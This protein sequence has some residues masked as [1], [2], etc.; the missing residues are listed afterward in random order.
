MI[1]CVLQTNTIQIKHKKVRIPTGRRLT[2]WLFTRCGGVEFGATEDKSILSSRAKFI[3]P[4]CILHCFWSHD[5]KLFNLKKS[6]KL[7]NVKI[8][9]GSCAQ[10]TKMCTFYF[11][12]NV[13]QLW[14]KIQK[15]ITW[16]IPCGTKTTCTKTS[17]LLCSH[18]HL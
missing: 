2:S 10:S 13:K 3:A 5:L 9:C 11:V 18:L 17:D 1:K 8:F 15:I 4:F 6:G 14:N 16:F 7:E 12:N